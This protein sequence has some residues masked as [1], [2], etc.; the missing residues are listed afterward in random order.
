MLVN[1]GLEAIV[2]TL[3]GNQSP[4]DL[5]FGLFIAGPGTIVPGTVLSDLTVASWGG[6]AGVPVALGG[7]GAA[8]IVGGNQALASASANITFSNT[9]GT[10]QTYIGWYSV[11]VT[12]GLL[13]EAVIFGTPQAIANGGTAV[14]TPQISQI[15]Q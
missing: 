6:Y 3:T 1:T 8:G 7:Y 10:A 11:G 15:S 2:N 12:S 14:F 13:Y 5:L 4:E 9:S